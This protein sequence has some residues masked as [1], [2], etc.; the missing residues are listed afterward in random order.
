MQ[1]S[2][3]AIENFANFDSVD[4][5]TDD[6][7]VVVGENKAGKSNLLRALRLVLDPTLPDR[8]RQLGLE[9]F[10]DGLGDQKL[11]SEVKVEVELTNFEDN[12]NLLA[13]LGGFLVSTTP[14]VIAR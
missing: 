13:V 6:S 3:I 14:Q 11:G 8:E 1:I 9:H 7:L 12:D 10:W 5:A 4:F 2:R